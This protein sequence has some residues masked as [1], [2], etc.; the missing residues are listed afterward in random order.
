MRKIYLAFAALASMFTATAQMDLPSNFYMQKLDNGLE[1]LVIEDNTVPLATVEIVVRNGSYTEDSSF[2]GLSH[3]YEHMFFKANKDI[4][5][6]EDF[7]KRVNELGI[8][9]NG[10]TSD[11]R[12]N[13]FFTLSN[14]NLKEGLLFMNSAIRYPLFLEQ[15]MKNENPVVDGEFQ[16][17][18]SN[19][20]FAMFQQFGREMWGENYYRKNPIGLHDVILT[21]TPEKMNIIKEKYYYP[22]N[23]MLVVAGDVDHNNVFPMVKEIY[24]SWE[25][26]DFDPF[27]KWPI[28]EMKPL[29]GE[30]MF[31]T[32]SPNAQV[33]LI[34]IG[35]HGPDTRN[36]LQS[37]YAADVF[38]Y[39]LQQASSKLQ[40]ELVETGLAFQVQVGYQTAKYTG[41]IQIILVPN[42]MK[43]QEAYNKLWEQ[44]SMWSDPDYF[45]DEQLETA[46]RL[47]AI[48]DA[49]G[50]ESTSSFVH[51]VTY[52]W[53]SATIGYYTNYVDNL[54]KVTREDIDRYIKTYISGKP[55]V[56]GL[57][58][59]PAMKDMIDL[60]GMGFV[61]AE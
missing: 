10:T 24:S 37:T 32:E 34:L 22:N 51:T 60:K 25:P 11:E 42:P 13:Y 6:Q 18:E 2:N 46:K 56:V 27:Q 52:W 29:E 39:I 23:S 43:V 15:E 47:L 61:K 58:L 1:V 49:Y 19:P 12:V 20:Y 17:G 14:R 45:T 53:A 36:D 48:D 7:L 55:H 31:L 38:S 26:C 33:P 40:Q 5:S 21:A 57:A 9:F 3:L 16:R 28:P 30:T 8:V 50:K 59:N 35:F 41:P 44:I 54:Q 4:P